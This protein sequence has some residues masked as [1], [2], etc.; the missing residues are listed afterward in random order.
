MFHR[1]TLRQSE[2]HGETWKKV[3]HEKCTLF[4]KINETVKHENGKSVGST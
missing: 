4:V 3:F 1:K 2:K